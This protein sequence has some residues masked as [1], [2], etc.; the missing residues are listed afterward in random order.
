[1]SWFPQT[2]ERLRYLMSSL[3]QPSLPVRPPSFSCPWTPNHGPGG[4]NPSNI[5]RRSPPRPPHEAEHVLGPDDKHPRRKNFFTL[6]VT[7][8][9]NRQHREVVESFLWRWSK[10]VWTLSSI[11]YS[12]EPGLAG[13]WTRW[14]AEVPSSPYNSMILWYCERKGRWQRH[15]L[16]VTVLSFSTFA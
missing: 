6:R 14:S 10:P 1:M 11:K 4:K 13:G 12:G 3:S 2:W 8:H 5:K 7:E 15:V 9:Q 16:Y